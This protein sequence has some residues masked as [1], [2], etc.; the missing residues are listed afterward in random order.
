MDFNEIKALKLKQLR[1]RMDNTPELKQ[2]LDKIPEEEKETLVE[3]IF[4][5]IIAEK[6]VEKLKTLKY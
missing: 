2:K 1:E 4:D 6:V 3:A 5:E